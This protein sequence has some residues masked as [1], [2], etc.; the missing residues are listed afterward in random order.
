[1]KQKIKQTEK[2]NKFI[3]TKEGVYKINSSF[4]ILKDE[5]SVKSHLKNN[6]YFGTIA[7]IISLIK[8]NLDNGINKEKVITALKNLEK[9]LVFLQENYEIKLKSKL[10]KA[11]NKKEK[12]NTERQT[13]KPMIKKHKQN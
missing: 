7:T 13:N 5:K 12:N 11:K 3:K 2:N 4:F 1:M 9:D 8:Q 10:N 6:D